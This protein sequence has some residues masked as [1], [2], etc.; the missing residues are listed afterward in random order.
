MAQQYAR[1]LV[2]AQWFEGLDEA[3]GNLLSVIEHERFVSFN[4]IANELAGTCLILIAVL[5]G[6][7]KTTLIDVGTIELSVEA[8]FFG[9]SLVVSNGLGWTKKYTEGMLRT[10]ALRNTVAVHTVFKTALPL[11]LGQLLQYSEWEILTIF[12]ASL[13]TAEVTTWGK[14]G[15]LKDC[16]LVSYSYFGPLHVR[17]VRYCRIALGCARIT[18]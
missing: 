7:N 8:I 16:R 13:G 12:V 2:F 14:P 10:N 11:A 4:A 17:T 1:F 9:F 6:D 18:Y 15:L 3:Y 5:G